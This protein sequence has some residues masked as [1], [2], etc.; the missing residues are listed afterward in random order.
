MDKKIA[1]SKLQLHPR[2]KHRE[3]YDFEQLSEYNSELKPYVV[4]RPDGTKSINFKKSKAV[5][6]LN[7]A[8][9]K[10]DY[11]I[12]FWQI[13]ENYLCPPIPGRVDYIHYAADLLADLTK[14]KEVPTGDKITVFDVGTGSSCIYPILGNHEFDWKFVA[15][16]IDEIA[17]KSASEI[18]DKN[19]SLKENVDLRFQEDHQH[20]FKGIFKDDE[21]FDLSICNPP[22]HGSEKQATAASTRKNTNLNISSDESNFGGQANELWYQGGELAFIKK[23]I[24]E[25]KD[26]P[27]RFL[28]FTTLVSKKD[29]L[30]SLSYFL[31]KEEITNFKIIDMAQGNKVS[32]MLAWSF[33]GRPAMRDWRNS[34]W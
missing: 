21:S 9:L 18:I 13:P 32:R 34:L 1:N 33:L 22:F 24:K 8:I 15:S 19:P 23:M 30:K 16:E 4:Q 20:F 27:Y 6:E 26:V 3:Q 7:K 5:I 17:F 12:D 11:E 31:E 28:W 2:N 14:D 29:N 25:S 10:K